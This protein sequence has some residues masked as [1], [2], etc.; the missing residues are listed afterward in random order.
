MSSTK[1]KIQLTPNVE[2]KSLETVKDEEIKKEVIESDSVYKF[3]YDFNITGSWWKMSLCGARVVLMLIAF[4]LSWRCNSSVNILFRLFIAILASLFSE[5]Y[6][7]YFFLY[8]T[9]LGYKCNPTSLGST[10]YTPMRYT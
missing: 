1:A 6:V 3:V 8:R 10:T 5:I 9:L 4:I 7:I 2:V